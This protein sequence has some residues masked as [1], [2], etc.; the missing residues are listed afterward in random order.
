MSGNNFYH[1]ISVFN[2]FV[3][4]LCIFSITYRLVAQAITCTGLCTSIKHLN[5]FM[6]DSISASF[7]LDIFPL[8][9]SSPSLLAPRGTSYLYKL[10]VCRSFIYTFIKLNAQRWNFNI[11]SSKFHVI[12]LVFFFFF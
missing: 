11:Y 2:F 12:K 8:K 10:R 5:A 4:F 7:C 6:V 3:L 9:C 1:I